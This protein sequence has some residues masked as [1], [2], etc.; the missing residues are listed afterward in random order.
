MQ[1]ASNKKRSFT[2]AHGSAGQRP[3]L[4]TDH[5]CL[6]VCQEGIIIANPKMEIIYGRHAG[7]CQ[8]RDEKPISVQVVSCQKLGKYPDNIL[9]YV[10]L[11]RQMQQAWLL[12]AVLP[13]F[14]IAPFLKLAGCCSPLTVGCR[15]LC[16]SC[17]VY[18]PERT[19]QANES[20]G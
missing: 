11:V 18:F 20:K 6:S 9:C 10:R 7:S 16:L 2:R 4:S 17:T 1:T 5:F 13:K 8:R 19:V 12:G 15:V 14:N 3:I